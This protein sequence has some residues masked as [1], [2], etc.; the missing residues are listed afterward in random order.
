MR[1]RLALTL[2]LKET[3][4]TVYACALVELEGPD[5]VEPGACPDGRAP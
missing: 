5:A 2:G 4:R 3:L 1:S